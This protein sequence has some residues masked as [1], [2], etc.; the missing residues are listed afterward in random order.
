M[1]RTLQLA[2]GSRQPADAI[3]GVVLL[4]YPLHPPG[5]PAQL[6]SAHLPAI[7]V[8][9]LFIQGSRDPFGTPAELQPILAGLS[10]KVTMHVVANGDHSLVPPKR[11][12]PSADGVY[13]ELQD[14]IVNWMRR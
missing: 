9:M 6:R 8:P 5:K 2:A 3:R 14:A 1:P 12:A 13:A 11:A 7:R 4:G 10:A